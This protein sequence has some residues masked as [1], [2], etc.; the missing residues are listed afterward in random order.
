MNKTELIMY[1]LYKRDNLSSLWY[2]TKLI[3]LFYKQLYEYILHR[4]TVQVCRL[5]GCTKQF[6]TLQ[7]LKGTVS[8]N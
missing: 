7:N 1:V 4:Y 2:C 8:A 6:V 5:V 3:K